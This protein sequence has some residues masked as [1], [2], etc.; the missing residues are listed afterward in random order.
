[1]ILSFIWGIIAAALAFSLPIIE[2]RFILY[3]ALGTILRSRVL[4]EWA[5]ADPDNYESDISATTPDAKVA[6]YVKDSPPGSSDSSE[7]IKA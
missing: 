6:N 5:A 2:S 4:K 1:M 3:S 7:G